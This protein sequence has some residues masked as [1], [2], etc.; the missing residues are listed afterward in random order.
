[1]LFFFNC[2]QQLMY[3]GCCAMQHI[4]ICSEAI[5]NSAICYL[6]GKLLFC[7][8]YQHLCLAFLYYKIRAI[9]LSFKIKM[10]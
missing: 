9:T 7:S 2:M 5:R 6:P 3:L 10:C 8:K 1:M 4:S